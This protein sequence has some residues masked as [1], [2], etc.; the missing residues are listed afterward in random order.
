MDEL[1]GT[2]HTMKCQINKKLSIECPSKC[3]VDVSSRSCDYGITL[4]YRAD[5]D[6]PP[7][8]RKS[9][10]SAPRYLI[11]NARFYSLARETVIWD[12]G[13]K[14]RDCNVI[15]ACGLI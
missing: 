1:T 6:L 3:Y 4:N 13:A 11:A 10:S 7:T 15:A 2:W 8:V 14:H 12:V 9:D 5:T